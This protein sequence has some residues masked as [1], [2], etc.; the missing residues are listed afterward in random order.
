[1]ITSRLLKTESIA[2]RLT[3]IAFK[4]Y[5][6]GVKFTEKADGLILWRAEWMETACGYYAVDAFVGDN[7]ASLAL[8]WLRQFAGDKGAL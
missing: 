5:D 2:A 3:R 6:L 4:R 1:M 8:N 7:Q